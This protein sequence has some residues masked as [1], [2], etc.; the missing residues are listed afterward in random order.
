M[1]YSKFNV[2]PVFKPYYN[3]SLMTCYLVLNDVNATMPL[4]C[5]GLMSTTKFTYCTR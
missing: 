5:V 4:H 3:E 2:M 1:K